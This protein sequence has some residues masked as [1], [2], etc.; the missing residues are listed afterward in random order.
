M[1]IVCFIISPVFMQ[2]FSAAYALNL[3][4]HMSVKT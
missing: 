4:K 1:N 3:L 2:Y